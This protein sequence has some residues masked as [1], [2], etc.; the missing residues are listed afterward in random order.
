MD[1]RSQRPRVFE[2][3]VVAPLAKVGAYLYTS[4]GTTV[5]EAHWAPTLQASAGIGF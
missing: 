2:G 1:A 5:M 3:N 4:S